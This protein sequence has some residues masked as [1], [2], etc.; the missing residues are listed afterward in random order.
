[1]KVVDERVQGGPSGTKVRESIAT[2][3]KAEFEKLTPKSVH[4][5]YDELKKYL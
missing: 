3:N 1:M 5:Y 4:Q 2:D